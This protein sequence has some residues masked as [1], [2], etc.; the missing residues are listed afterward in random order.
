[1]AGRT[2]TGEAEQVWLTLGPMELE[3]AASPP[4]IPFRSIS[5]NCPNPALCR[6]PRLWCKAEGYRPSSH[7]GGHTARFPG[8]SV[9]RLFHKALGAGQRGMLGHGAQLGHG[10]FLRL[11]CHKTAVFPSSF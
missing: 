7:K 6:S 2:L 9:H 8:N 5:W 3:E 10:T 1:M 11:W 4:G